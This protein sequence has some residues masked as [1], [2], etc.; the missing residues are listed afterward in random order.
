M[1]SNLASGF[2]VLAA[3][4]GGVSHEANAAET[5]TAASDL[6]T[7]S[8]TIELTDGRRITGIVDARTTHEMLWLRRVEESI[9]M[10]TGFAWYDIAELQLDD[11][12]L[13]PEVARERLKPLASAR[14]SEAAIDFWAFAAPPDV[15]TDEP[16]VV[17]A[18]TP[19]EEVLPVMIVP[20][21]PLAPAPTRPVTLRIEAGLGN[22]DA[23][24]EADGLWVSV[25]PLDGAG[26]LVPVDG[27]INFTV[28]GQR[29]QNRQH[30]DGRRHELFPELT[31]SAERVR[32]SDFIAI[33]GNLTAAV[34][35]VPFRNTHPEFNFDVAPWVVV[36]A[37]LGITGVGVLQA[38]TDDVS[39]RYPS[40]IR[41]RAQQVRGRRFFPQE[42][43]GLGR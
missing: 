33:D 14:P 42:N 5:L 13:T 21:P 19:M 36:T 15:L 22:W 4:C 29:V 16:A 1:R 11:A 27:H 30:H 37:R 18:P 23:D 38:S 28:I 26:E 8:V 32:R 35:Q 40:W 7:T 6:E 24:P 3:L 31:R 25:A 17:A 20:V 2:L 10:R 43:A 34:Y 39:V 41:D 12:A 9:V